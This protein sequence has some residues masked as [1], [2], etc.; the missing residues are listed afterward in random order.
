MNV[1]YMNAGF[2][3][4]CVESFNYIYI[5]K[6]IPYGIGALGIYVTKLIQIHVMFL[7]G[8]T[9]LLLTT[10]SHRKECWILF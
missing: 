8:T 9:A 10:Q 1:R 6:N 3:K 2:V 4:K 5:S 7:H